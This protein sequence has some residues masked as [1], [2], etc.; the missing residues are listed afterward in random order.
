[1]SEHTH[2]GEAIE[3]TPFTHGESEGHPFRGN[4]YGGYSGT[5]SEVQSSLMKK[6]WYLE[7]Y[8]QIALDEG[9]SKVVDILIDNTDAGW[10]YNGALTKASPSVAKMAEEMKTYRYPVV[11]ANLRADGK[12]HIGDGQHRVMAQQL[13][14]KTTIP[15]IVP[16]EDVKNFVHGESEGHPFRGNQYGEGESVSINR[17]EAGSSK[18][19]DKA[20]GTFPTIHEAGSLYHSTFSK[21]ISTIATDGL[22]PST[23][24][25]FEGFTSGDVVS[26]SPSLEDAKYWSKMSLWAEYDRAKISTTK[27]TVNMSKPVLLRVNGMTGEQTRTDEVVVHKV[28]PSKI[29]LWNGATWEPIDKTFT[30]GELTGHP[31]RGNQWGAGES[32]KVSEVEKKLL[33]EGYSSRQ[34]AIDTRKGL[35]EDFVKYED[36]A[37]D[38]EGINY[39]QGSGGVAINDY[40]R[41]PDHYEA[42]FLRHDS[43][44][45]SIVRSVGYMDEAFNNAP[46]APEGTVMWRGVGEKSG[47][48]IASMEVGDICDD[49]GFQSHSLSANVAEN[50]SKGWFTP[51]W[52]DQPLS[53]KLEVH[54]TI[55]RA[56]VGKNTKVV[57]GGVIGEFEMLVNRG[58]KWKVAAKET[59]EL[60]TG[61]GHKQNT[62]HIMTVVPAEG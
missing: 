32:G 5:S 14:G 58:T 34:A 6:G 54:R 11:E 4:Q 22:A 39:Y 19:F 23:T 45:E 47:F 1:M 52:E 7:D 33:V 57:Y 25:T 12:W 31:F 16:K 60:T 56:V 40:L 28:E 46:S 3:L 35:P 10:E 49:K 29:E 37:H 8:Q 18:A 27:D 21:N 30:H 59:F 41:D 26:L 2:L 55:I 20:F 62:Y 17:K 44:K 9:T 24:K 42:N 15:A 36:K 13:L 43:D 51:G 50:F 53:T 48:K 61:A 38:N